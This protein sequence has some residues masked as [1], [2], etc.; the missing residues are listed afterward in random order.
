[1]DRSA[2]F[3][4]FVS[5]V[6]GAPVTRH[7]TRTFIGC[8]RRA[9]EPTIIDYHPEQIVAISH[10]EFRKYRREYLRALKDGSLVSHTADEWRALN[11]QAPDDNGPP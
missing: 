7:G 11:R 10:E 8:E 3:A 1:M 4:L 5:C 2:A 9:L 6:E